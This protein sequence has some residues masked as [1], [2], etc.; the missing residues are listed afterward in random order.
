MLAGGFR[1]GLT[2]F[3]SS[4]GDPIASVNAFRGAMI[5]LHGVMRVGARSEISS[6]IGASELSRDC[7]PIVFAITGVHDNLFMAANLD[8]SQSGVARWCAG[9]LPTAGRGCR[10][11]PAPVPGR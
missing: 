8:L 3:S 5:D 6:I 10:E 2:Y 7:A 4:T 9:S 11:T 1:T